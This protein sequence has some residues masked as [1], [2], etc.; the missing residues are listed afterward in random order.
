MPDD[1]S[2]LCQNILSQLI[3][4]ILWFY[5]CVSLIV[6]HDWFEMQIKWRQNVENIR[7]ETIGGIGYNFVWN[8]KDELRCGVEV[9]LM[10]FNWKV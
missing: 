10:V 8:I 9:F 3:R 5:F 1:D 7:K 2:V 6:I 4:F